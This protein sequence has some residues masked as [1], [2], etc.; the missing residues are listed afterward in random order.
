MNDHMKIAMEAAREAG[1]MLK[2]NFGKTLDVERKA[3]LSLVTNVDKEAERIILS[4]IK[5]AF[6]T[7]SVLAEES[8]TERGDDF[9]WVI[10]PL[11]GTHNYVRGNVMYGVSIG[12]VHREEFV[13]GVIYLPATDEM[14]AAERG[15]G[16]FK[17]EKPVRVSG[18]SEL[19]QS[20]LLFDSGLHDGVDFKLEVLKR[21]SGSMFNVRMLGASSRNLTYVAEGK[22]D[23]IVEFDEKPWDF[24]AGVVL[25][26]EAGGEISG[27]HEES[28]T[29]DS[30]RYIAGNG[31]LNG[32]MRELVNRVLVNIG[33]K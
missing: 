16:A 8:G 12:L 15:L 33:E 7:H 23:L 31:L 10:D 25:I 29:I 9:T 2:E 32:Q 22:A 4:R 17:N 21:I 18:N 27:F 20:T 19:S 11:D 13:A 1:L 26:R 28:V 3:D 24:V 6:P 30:A 14:Y 5:A